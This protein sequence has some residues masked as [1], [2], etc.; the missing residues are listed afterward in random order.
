MV[1]SAIA[2]I[3]GTATTTTFQDVSAWPIEF[4]ARI[5][6][7]NVPP[8]V[9][10][11]AQETTPVVESIDMSAGPFT[12]DHVIGSVPWVS[13]GVGPLYD[14]PAGMDA[15]AIAAI[16]GGAS[17]VIDQL[18]SPEPMRLVARMVTEYGVVL[19]AGLAHDTTPVVGL[20]VIPTGPFANDHVIGGVPAR[21]VGAGPAY[22]WP[23]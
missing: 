23:I 4:V 14:P 19:Q 21:S 8:A 2:R 6:T 18:A 11:A 13:V 9:A 22:G 10:G 20:I 1:A 17:T 15:S 3:C 16:S 7:V 12:S 5:V